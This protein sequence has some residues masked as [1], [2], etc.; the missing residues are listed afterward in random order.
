MVHFVQI[1]IDV[2]RYVL[3][4]LVVSRR[5]AVLQELHPPD[6]DGE[7]VFAFTAPPLLVTIGCHPFPHRDGSHLSGRT[8]EMNL[9]PTAIFGIFLAAFMVVALSAC[10]K[11]GVTCERNCWEQIEKDLPSG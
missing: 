8:G 6:A 3:Y 10:S 5:R 1:L 9:T 4:M 7:L 11:F 2:A